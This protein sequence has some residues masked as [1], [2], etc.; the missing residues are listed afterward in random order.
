[1]AYQPVQDPDIRPIQ[2]AHFGTI[3][4][5]TRY[6]PAY[7]PAHGR[8]PSISRSPDGEWKGED[9]GD[10]NPFFRRSRSTSWSTTWPLPPPPGVRPS[11]QAQQVATLTPL[12][13][14]LMVFDAVLASTPIMFVGEFHLNLLLLR[15]MR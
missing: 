13:A 14:G 1:M 8:S 9:M 12:R 2:P 4:L 6:D 10:K 7:A 11:V 15:G 5:D 3:E